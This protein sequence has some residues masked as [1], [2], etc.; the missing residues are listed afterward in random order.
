[1]GA[2][3]AEAQEGI[4]VVA[5]PVKGPVGVTQ[6]RTVLLINGDRDDDAVLFPHTVHQDR[7]GGEKSCA[8]CHHQNL[9]HDNASA[10]HTCHADMH[11]KTP[12]F[13]HDRHV[14]ALGDK[15]SC[16]ECHEDSGPKNLQS[17]L[18]CHECHAD[19]M[20]L[21]PPTEGR[22]DFMARSYMEAMH[23]QCMTCHEEEDRK[24]A[25]VRM[26]EC[27]FCHGEQPS[28]RIAGATKQSLLRGS[29][30]R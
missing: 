29:V 12:I 23:G 14:A 25:E 16:R 27:Q 20:G 22:Y 3:S 13:D 15:W 7:L 18:A 2:F 21:S 11:R 4:E 1:M 26:A 5:T 17:S 19:D 10:C 6:A 9:P 24:H 8:E 28:L 30:E